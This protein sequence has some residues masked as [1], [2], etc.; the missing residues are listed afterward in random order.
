[1]DCRVLS[2]ARGADVPRRV[3]T[4]HAD[5]T[6]TFAGSKYARITELPAGCESLRLDLEA[7]AQWR[8]LYRALVP[9]RRSV[10]RRT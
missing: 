7:E 5:G 10:P 6:I 3:G 9:P 4:L 1:M 8:R 2:F